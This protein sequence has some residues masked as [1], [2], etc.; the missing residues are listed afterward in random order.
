MTNVNIYNFMNSENW[1]IIEE[2]IETK[3]EI[4]G[5]DIYLRLY[6]YFSRY[7]PIYI[8]KH[9]RMEGNCNNINKINR[10]FKIQNNFSMHGI[11]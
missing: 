1:I 5:I 10:T 8:Q 11:I 6:K 2:K 7:T 4:F 9:I 3:L